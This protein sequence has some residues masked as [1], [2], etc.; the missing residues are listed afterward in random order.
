MK[1][2]DGMKK[3]AATR[4]ASEVRKTCPGTSCGN[5]VWTWSKRNWVHVLLLTAAVGAV[6][7]AVLGSLDSCSSE[8]RNSTVTTYNTT[9]TTTITNVTTVTPVSAMILL[10]SSGSM[11]GSRYTQAQDSMPYLTNALW[12]GLNNITGLN[13]TD[14]KLFSGLL[15]W[16]SATEDLSIEAALQQGVTAT[17]NAAAAMTIVGGSTHWG[18]ALCEC[19]RQ[20]M[21]TSPV[22]AENLCILF[23]DGGISSTDALG[24]V[25][26]PGGA[27]C[28]SD[29]GRGANGVC[30]C[31]YLWHDESPGGGSSITE[32]VGVENYLK[33][34]NVT[35]FSI[36]VGD[37]SQSSA[38]TMFDAASCSGHTLTGNSVTTCPYYLF[39]N[40]FSDLISRAEAIAD[41]QQQLS[42]K[43]DQ[44]STTVQTTT[45][46]VETVT[47]SVS[48]CSLDFLYALL[49]FVPF[50]AYLIYRV[51]MI[52][53]MAKTIKQQLVQR[54]K[55]GTLSLDDLKKF[56]T[57]ATN[58][59]LPEA[60]PSDIDWI[61]SY[62]LHHCPCLRPASKGDLEAVFA[63]TT[64]AL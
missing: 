62:I 39:L 11:S 28:R 56:A 58:M 20:M 15:Q 7:G 64:I 49:A 47:G 4:R 27:D 24:S 60:F 52:R 6:V 18:K 10:D 34:K 57:V 9:N 21:T 23:A 51:V 35:I 14:D 25:S 17:N 12:Q 33:S 29:G 3:G 44:Q 63:A 26:G 50:L 54:I 32:H 42:L 5:K 53:V 2:F 38:D 43:V 19:Y 37:S 22:N 13:V 8:T 36:L 46:A 1:K 59:L 30:E 55:N 48:V 31:D 61:I 41:E 45:S 40:E 16:S